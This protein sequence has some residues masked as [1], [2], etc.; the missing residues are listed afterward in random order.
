MYLLTN[1]LTKKYEILLS[2]ETYCTLACYKR[3][4]KNDFKTTC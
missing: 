4:Y 1:K 2:M 3:C